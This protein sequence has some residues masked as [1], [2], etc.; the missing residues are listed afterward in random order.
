[1]W[2]RENTGAI[3]GPVMSQC[4]GT[5]MNEG[6]IPQRLNLAKFR[7]LR[8]IPCPGHFAQWLDHRPEDILG[9]E[10]VTLCWVGCSN[11]LIINTWFLLLLLHSTLSPR[12]AG[13]HYDLRSLPQFYTPC[14]C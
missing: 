4:D 2:N 7:I 1:M 12:H 6:F 11:I 14:F 13:F 10:I 5:G 8:V 3:L 9:S